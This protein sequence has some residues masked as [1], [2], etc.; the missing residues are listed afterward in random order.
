[1]FSVRLWLIFTLVHHKDPFWDLYYFF[2]YN[3]DSSNNI[4]S[5]FKQFADDTSLFSIVHN[6]V[7]SANDFNHDLEKISE[8]DENK[9]E[10]R[11]YQKMKFNPDP[12]KQAREVEF[13]KKK[14][15]NW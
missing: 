8:Q 1:M 5:K 12:T 9:V 10:N 11:K 7:T 2:I 15:K 4:K 3:N 13:S 14:T 6:I